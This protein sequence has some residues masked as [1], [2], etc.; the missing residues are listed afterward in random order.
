M[1]IKSG[2]RTA[3]QRIIYSSLKT[4]SDNSLKLLQITFSIIVS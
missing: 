4:V 3:Q 1:N 2:S